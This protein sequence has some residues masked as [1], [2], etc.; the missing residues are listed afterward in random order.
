MAAGSESA[1]DA[2]VRV[3][4]YALSPTDGRIP[5]LPLALEVCRRDPCGR[6]SGVALLVDGDD[7]TGSDW[8]FRIAPNAPAAD[9]GP[10]SAPIP[11]R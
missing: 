2:T 8:R 4:G 10:V 7:P 3:S 5:T 11:P 1:D 6:L 9:G